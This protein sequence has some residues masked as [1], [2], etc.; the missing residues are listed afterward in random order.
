LGELPE[1]HLLFPRQANSVFVKL[2]ERAIEAMHQRGWW[3]YTF[4]GQGGC[5][6]M[7][8]WDTTEQ[9]VRAFVTE[10]KEVLRR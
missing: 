4:I 5:R 7:C 9:E 2:P 10:L 1:V 6:L 8:S 3:F